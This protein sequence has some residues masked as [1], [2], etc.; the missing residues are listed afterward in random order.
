MTALKIGKLPDTTPIRLS[1]AISP[2]LQVELD[3]YAA[4]YADAYGETAKVA[5]LIPSMLASFMASDSRFK[6]ARKALS[7]RQQ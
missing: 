6:K 2:E 7:T 1:I 3:D 4:V 5:D